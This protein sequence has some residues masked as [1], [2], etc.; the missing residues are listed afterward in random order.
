M[1]TRSLFAVLRIIAFVI[2][3]TTFGCGKDDG[4][5]APNAVSGTV[6]GTTEVSLTLRGTSVYETT[7]GS[8]GQF[9]LKGVANGTYLLSPSKSGYDFSPSEV[10]VVVLDGT[11]QLPPFLATA[12]TA[13][14]D[15]L[16]QAELARIDGI[17]DDPL[18][19]EALRLPDGDN[20]VAYAAAQGISIPSDFLSTER[21]ALQSLSERLASL[22]ISSDPAI[23]RKNVITMM[24][25][26]AKAYATRSRWKYAA[27]PADPVLNPAE[28]GLSY[29]W[30]GKTPKVRTA[31]TDGCL[32]RLHGMDC[33]GLILNVAAAAGITID[34]ALAYAKAEEL[35]PTWNKGAIP[36][37]YGLQMELVTDGSIQSGDVV[38]WPSHIGLAVTSDSD[39]LI[40]SST[41]DRGTCKANAT[42][43]RGPRQLAL[44]RLGLGKPTA[45]LRLKTT[46]NRYRFSTGNKGIDDRLLVQLVDPD[47]GAL[48]TLVSASFGPPIADVD[49]SAKPGQVLVIVATD[50]NGGACYANPALSLTNL[51][52]PSKGVQL[53]AAARSSCTG[54][55][56]VTGPYDYLS[57]RVAIAI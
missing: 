42:A 39:P 26:V 35:T 57:V 47:S 40:I 25:L 56:V 31:G 17:P 10:K 9:V 38:G 23:Q 21:A 5:E 30:G 6:S 22:P 14:D 54:V 36:N 53:L 15:A 55:R 32:Q 1:G 52:D 24:M 48:T 27:D 34:P 2:I 3:I 43:P 51:D 13:H 18:A 12:E 41:G 45:V 28:N 50:D 46:L 11:V 49:F 16:T 29:I 20:L 19:L 44:S 37:A 33:S 8:S 7:T 4:S